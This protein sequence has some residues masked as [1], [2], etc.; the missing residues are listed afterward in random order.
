[1][2][3]ENEIKRKGGGSY[4][5]ETGRRNRDVNEEEERR[6]L[7]EGVWGEKK[8]N[9]AHT[10]GTHQTSWFNQ[11]QTT[12]QNAPLNFRLEQQSADL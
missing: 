11:S 12:L 5:E 8:R 7:S 9:A 2:N 1:M 4:G 3:R 10:P 6:R